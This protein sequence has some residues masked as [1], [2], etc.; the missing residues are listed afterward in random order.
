MGWGY[1]TNNEGREVGYS[2]EAT[3]DQ[4]GCEVEIDR[5]LGYVCG[6][7]HDAGFEVGCGR[8]FCHNGHLVYTGVDDPD[9]G[10]DR[11]PGVQLCLSCAAQWEAEALHVCED[12]ECAH[13]GVKHDRRADPHKHDKPM[14][15]CSAPGCPCEYW[16][17]PS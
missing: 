4:D 6:G 10:E 5:G 11:S 3:C 14:P 2:V 1:G 15:A 7:M 12:E 17:P 16:Q 13:L 9:T 8:Y